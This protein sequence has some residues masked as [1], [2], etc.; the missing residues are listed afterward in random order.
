M[1]TKIAIVCKAQ[2]ALHNLTEGILAWLDA[3]AKTKPPPEES[4]NDEA[5][6]LAKAW[7]WRVFRLPSQP[8]EELATILEVMDTI[9][10]TA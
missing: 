3:V 5:E 8:M 2:M 1:N 4:L 10:D 7:D 9:I 6:R